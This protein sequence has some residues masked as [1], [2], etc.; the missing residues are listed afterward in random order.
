MNRKTDILVVGGSVTRPDL[1][2]NILQKEKYLVFGTDN[3]AKAL[4]ILKD[5]RFH[6]ILSD[7]DIPGLSGYELCRKV[8][9]DPAMKDIPVILLSAASDPTDII[10]GLECG[11]DNFIA[12]PFDPD[13]LLSWVKRHLVNMDLR[14]DGTSQPG[15]EFFLGGHKHK[16]TADRM[17][18]L[19]ILL[20]TYDSAAQRNRDL[21]EARLRL[22]QFNG[23][24]EVQVRERTAALRREVEARARAEEDLRGARQ[25][26]DMA[27]QILPIAFFHGQRKGGALGIEWISEDAERL[28]G[29]NGSKFTGTKD[30]WFS[31][32]HPEDKEHVLADIARIAE[33]ANTG[34][35]CRW[36]TGSGE[37]RWFLSTF[38]I[39]PGSERI[40]GMMM[41]VSEKKVLELQFRESQKLE[42]VGR[43]AG[44]IAHD[45]NNL[46]TA[47]NGYADF[48]IGKMEPGDK[49]RDDAVEIK[50]AA[51]AAA[52]LTRQLLIFS[53]RQVVQTRVLDCNP[54]IR[55]LQK[56]LRRL[57]G[58]NIKI[59][60]DLAKEECRINGDP[61]YLEQII[62]NLVI[63]AR[64]A[65][66]D[67]GGVTIKTENI[68]LNGEH[69]RTHLEPRSG[70]HVKISVTDTG[71]GMS[72]DVLAR[73]FE[74]LFTTKAVGKG[75]GLGLATVYGIVKQSGGDI[76]V[77]SEPGLGSAFR[78]YLPRVAESVEAPAEKARPKTL[79]G[80]E[81]I[82]LVE[83][84]D[85][86]RAF[87]MRA[88]QENGYTVLEARGPDEAA[89]ICSDKGAGI[90]LILTDT[91][92]PVMDGH[93]MYSIISR[94]CPE[95][96]VLFMS[97]Y[98]ETEL[99]N[100]HLSNSGMPFLQKPFSADTLAGKVREVLDAREAARA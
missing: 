28:F 73:M 41:D 46:L 51:R 15:L 59:E 84:D 38:A 93:K 78:V 99:A 53:R 94:R 97:G 29:F 1:V 50:R 31:R 86:V 88:L 13:Y 11:A 48:L 52:A 92:M 56:M 5:R 61:G 9:N 16:L 54:V 80:L 69:L 26:E 67:G 71:C 87:A 40:I 75:T 66:P 34:S 8:K 45:F 23:S 12:R 27:R 64:D 43:L 63:N 77:Y 72:P 68:V 42:A 60:L 22:E 30:F 32:V 47:I 36:Q 4:K 65:M 62:M 20:S 96:K 33:N 89:S 39:K 82:L 25:H 57:I 7:I 58:E 44:G 49:R 95:V 21:A 35:E 98:T 81:T 3:G 100:A 10:R 90:N 74:P 24:L 6:I 83:D 14:R 18:I 79:R 70:P 55:D 76:G 17:Q 85:G 37:Y 91:I 2:T 19:D